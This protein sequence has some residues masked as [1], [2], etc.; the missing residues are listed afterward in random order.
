VPR[1]QEGRFAKGTSGNLR[2]RPPGT[3]PTQVEIFDLRAAARRYTEESI[4]VIAE[5]LRH[6]DARIRLLAADLMLQR[7]W[8]KPEI[9][10]EVTTHAFVVCPEVMDEA[11][12]LER[13]GQP[14]IEGKAAPDVCPMH[15]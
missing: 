4:R 2:G 9:K 15:R 5:C 1:D 12:W 13:R 14:L 3:S 11:L 7:G 8:G 10:A 6:K